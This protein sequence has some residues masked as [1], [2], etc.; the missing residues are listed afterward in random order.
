MRH[1]SRKKICGPYKHLI[2]IGPKTVKGA[3]SALNYVSRLLL[4]CLPVS[5]PLPTYYRPTI[6]SECLQGGPRIIVMPLNTF[7]VECLILECYHADDRSLE[8]V[9]TAYQSAIVRVHHG[10]RSDVNM[11]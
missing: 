3:Q 8:R 9:V 1:F 6:R 7:L 2:L 4:D 11:S 10:E 5:S